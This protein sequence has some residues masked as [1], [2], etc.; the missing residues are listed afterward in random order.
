MAAISERPP[1]PIPEPCRACG[2]RLLRAFDSVVLGDVPVVYGICEHCRS[3]MLPAPTWLDRAYSIKYVPHPDTGDLQR[4]LMV[5]RVTRRL[6][7]LG[8]LPPGARCLDFGVG[9]GILLR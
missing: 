5:W 4:C 2:G 3:L 6:R 8:L 9:K 7:S 1:H